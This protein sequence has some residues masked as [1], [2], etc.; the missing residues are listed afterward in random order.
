MPWLTVHIT[1]P[2]ILIGGWAIGE[3]IE[4]VDWNRVQH[5]S[6]WIIILVG[7]FGIL[8]L[9][10]A[11]GYVLGTTPP[12]A[13]SELE[14]LRVT[15]GFLIATAVALGSFVGVVFAAKDWQGLEILHLAGLTM[16]ALLS[17]LTVRT[18]FRAAFIKYD[19]AEEYLVYAHSAP[20]VKT[21]LEQVEELSQRTSDGLGID[22]GY[23][24]DVSWPYSWYL[25]DFTNVHYYEANPTRDLANYPVVIAGND[26][27]DKVES[28]L[29][30]R[31][32]EFEYIRMW[33]PMQEY[34]GL[35]WDRILGAISSP[36][37]R[38]A[39]WDIWFHR[40][41]EAYGRLI[42]RDFS[43]ENWSPS[44]E[45]K[46]Y[47]RK[48]MAALIWDYGVAPKTLEEAAAVDPY[49]Q[50][51][52]DLA[53]GQIIGSPGTAIGEFQ[54]PR[55]LAVGPADALFVADTGNHRIVRLSPEGE[56]VATWGRFGASEE[57][58]PVPLFNEPWGL[59]AAPDG[60]LYVADTW[61]H[62]V[63][64]LSAEGEALGAF[65]T[66]GQGED[67][68]SLWGP[69]DVAVDARGRVFVADTGNKRVVVFEEGEP[70]ASFGGVGVGPGQLDEPV[71]L[72]I[73]PEGRVF[74]ADTWNQRVQVFE[75]SAEGEFVA[76]H[77]WPLDAWFGQSLNNKPYLAV[78]DGGSVCVSDPEG[79][80]VICFNSQGQFLK[81]WGDPGA[82]PNQLGLPVGVAFQG[83]SLWVIDSENSRVM[84]FDPSLP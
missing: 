40:D 22:L 27:W 1:L 6:G 54:A 83:E 65:G 66:Y 47:V 15:S 17:I 48:D 45:M 31:Y 28:I 70:V 57:S 38:A 84:E 78:S 44:D 13:G 42:D 23:D 56:P 35:T 26:N 60:S 3:A 64:H 79:Y 30:D 67:L 20:G 75:E 74:V 76:V 61:N 41:Y 16:L 24:N 63:Q 33:W 39:L 62:R 2:F 53:A 77:E 34:F 37:Y 73:G 46:L 68:Q 25:R 9:L 81:A 19:R 69:R 82:G 8:A 55:G 18:A 59:A 11:L 43:L 10:R 29:R 49:A 14:Q 72:A 50:G 80:R 32:F 52:V 5:E 21:V 7:L 4:S 58:A 71:G 51:T 36:Q 12:F